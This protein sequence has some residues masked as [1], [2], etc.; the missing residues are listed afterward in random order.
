[1][2]PFRATRPVER[3][4]Y[5]RAL[6]LDAVAGEIRW[7]GRLVWTGTGITLLLA[8]GLSLVVAR[9]LTRPLVELA[10]AAASIAQGDYGK[11]VLISDLGGT[12]LFVLDAASR[13]QVKKIDLS[14]RAAG[15]LMDPNGSRAFVAVGSANS[16]AVIDLNELKLTQRV[17][18]GP[19]PDGLAWAEM[20]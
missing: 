3:V 17:E 13:A 14:G 4:R 8:L 1:M 6:P 2:S 10:Q 20:K 7:L 19:G 5:Q 15:I 9:R 12:D 16:V 11:R 18:A